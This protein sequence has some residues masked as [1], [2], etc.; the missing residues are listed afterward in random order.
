VLP[1]IVFAVDDAFCL[2][3]LV[4]LESLGGPGSI[5][6]GALTVV[7][8]HEGLSERSRDLIDRQAAAL[9]LRV[10]LAEAKLPDL[11]Y[12][13]AFG[14]SRGNYLRLAVPQ[15]VPDAPRAV[16]LDA[17]IVVRAPIE[18]LLRADLSG[19]PIGAVRDSVNPT[20]A[21]GDALPNWRALGLDG[22]REYFNSGVMVLDLPACAAA[23]VFTG[24]FEAV[25]DHAE[26]LRL[27]DQDALNLAVGD[28]WHRLARTWNTIPYSALARVPWVRYRAESVQPATELVAAEASASI[29]HY[30]SPAKPWRGLLP[31]GPANDLYQHHLSAVRRRHPGILRG[32]E[33]S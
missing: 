3:L 8:M 18:D 25:A 17:D 31:A 30:V 26:H 4:A 7:V 32:K 19:C 5:D 2:P 16:Y 33:A 1:P 23:G 13:T 28:R 9:G 6:P 21:T 12:N 24:A 14:G 29:M 22:S 10:G 27:W 15:V 20:L 11:E